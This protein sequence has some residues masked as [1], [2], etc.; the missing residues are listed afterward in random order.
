MNTNKGSKQM[1][2]ITKK[3]LKATENISATQRKALAGLAEPK[4]RWER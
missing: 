4:W 2:Q 1:A 3:W